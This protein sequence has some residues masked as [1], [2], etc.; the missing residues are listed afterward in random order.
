M[1]KAIIILLLIVIT[2]PGYGIDIKRL[3]IESI[4]ETDRYQ[5]HRWYMYTKENPEEIYIEVEYIHNRE[6]VSQRIFAGYGYESNILAQSATREEFDK[7][8]DGAKYLALNLPDIIEE[9]AG[10]R[11][12]G[13]F[14][15]Y[16]II[17]RQFHSIM[18]NNEITGKLGRGQQWTIAYSFEF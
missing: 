16:V 4:I 14:L 5:S 3:L 17:I 2:I 11:E 6:V 8:I 1:K 7:K 12:L 15:Q 13:E 18:H 10:D 9:L